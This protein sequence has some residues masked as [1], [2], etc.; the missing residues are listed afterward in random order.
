MLWGK[1]SKRIVGGVWAV[2]SILVIVSMV[3]L[4][5]LPVF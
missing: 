5:M 4:Y 1:K 3:L 2:I